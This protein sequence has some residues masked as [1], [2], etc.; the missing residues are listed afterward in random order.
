MTPSI[1]PEIALSI[2]YAPAGRRQALETIWVLDAQLGSV[3]RSTSEPMIGAMRLTWWRDAIEALGQG[4]APAEPLLQQLDAVLVARGQG[5]GRLPDMA[6]GWI[7]LLDPFPLPCA[8]LE[9]YARQRGGVLF[10]E[11][12]RFLGA[13]NVPAIAAAGAGW[14][15]VDFAFRCSDRATAGAALELARPIL[16]EALAARWAREARSLGMLAHL[17]LRDAEAGPGV[18]RRTGSPGRALRMLRHRITGR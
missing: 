2:A 4:P 13:A 6:E 17:A 10:E 5:V 9:D 18:P 14:A 12:G 11:L 8:A 1:D 3:V 15:L 7:V 16:R